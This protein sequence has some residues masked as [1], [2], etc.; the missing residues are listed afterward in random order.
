MPAN[1]DVRVV[2]AEANFQRIRDPPDGTD[3]VPHSHE[4]RLALQRE[5]FLEAKRQFQLLVVAMLEDA[6]NVGDELRVIRRKQAEHM[7]HGSQNARGVG[8]AAETE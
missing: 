5:Y 3:R 8:A 4:M 2:G 1:V 6:K 7:Q